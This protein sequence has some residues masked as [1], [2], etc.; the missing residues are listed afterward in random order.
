M[1]DMASGTFVFPVVTTIQLASQPFI[2]Q[3]PERGTELMLQDSRE[4]PPKVI[5]KP[6][7]SGSDE[8]DA[9]ESE[10]ET[11]PPKKA[12]GEVISGTSSIASQSAAA[13]P[14]RSNSLCQCSNCIL[15]QQDKAT[16]SDPPSDIDDKENKAVKLSAGPV[17]DEYSEWGDALAFS[18][19]KDKKPVVRRMP[20]SDSPV[21]RNALVVQQAKG[22]I[23]KVRYD[24]GPHQKGWSGDRRARTR[25]DYA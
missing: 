21:K 14:M 4:E 8:T 17:P 24:P 18:T 1:R 20:L 2:A 9:S 12:E 11:T 23:C 7:D 10:N 5:S 16:A 22:T 19:R 6:C 15:K 13:G 3:Q 25:P